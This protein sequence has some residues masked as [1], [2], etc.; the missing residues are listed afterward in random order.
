MVILKFG[1][2]MRACQLLPGLEHKLRSRHVRVVDAPQ[3][4]V[5]I[6][7]REHLRR[8][9]TLSRRTLG[10]KPRAQSRNFG[11]QSDLRDQADR[12]EY[13]K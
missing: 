4:L 3:A 1:K 13:R 9:D 5:V 8:G 7:L 2:M 6:L 11:R 10:E 12:T